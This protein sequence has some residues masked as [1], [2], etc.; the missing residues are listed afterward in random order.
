M[1]KLCAALAL[2]LLC[3]CSH[4]YVI[5]LNNGMRLTTASKPRLQKGS[6]VYKDAKGKVC[7][8][9]EGRVREI[10]PESMSKEPTAQFKSSGR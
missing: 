5:T 9:P 1:K 10:A 2:V 8:V 3:G 6:Y 4:T 7:Y